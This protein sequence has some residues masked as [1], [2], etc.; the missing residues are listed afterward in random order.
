M[1]Y[2]LQPVSRWQ[3]MNQGFKTYHRC[4][5]CQSENIQY[6]KVRTISHKGYA[7]ACG[8]CGKQF[9]VRLKLF[10]RSSAS[11]VQQ[12]PIQESLYH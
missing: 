4:S 6:F 12:I 2:L 3:V 9:P 11:S 7:P 5:Q 10:K 1:L 8:D